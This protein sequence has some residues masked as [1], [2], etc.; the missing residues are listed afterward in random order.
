MDKEMSYGKTKRRNTNRCLVSFAK[1]IR[2]MERQLESSDSGLALFLCLK[3]GSC[4]RRLKLL[5]NL[6]YERKYKN[7]F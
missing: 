2:Y 6:K 5:P 7:G 1:D 3:P 4:E